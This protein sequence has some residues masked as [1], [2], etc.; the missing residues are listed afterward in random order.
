[1]RALLSWNEGSSRDT[2]LPLADLSASCGS[3]SSEVRSSISLIFLLPLSSP[4][5]PPISFSPVFP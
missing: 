3:T 1:M 5:P 2:R 4:N